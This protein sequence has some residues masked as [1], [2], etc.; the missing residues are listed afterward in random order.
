[1]VSTLPE[2]RPEP[3]QQPLSWRPILAA[4]ATLYAIVFVVLNTDQV[5]VSFVFFKAETS[6]LVLILLSMGLGAV[7]ALFGPAYWRRRQRLRKL[8]GDDR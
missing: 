2:K 3:P 5:G 7:L 6:L 8:D 4:A 1:M